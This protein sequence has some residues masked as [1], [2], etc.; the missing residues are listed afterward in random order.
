M[1]KKEKSQ[2]TIA[3]LM[4][5]EG[6]SDNDRSVF[7]NT[8]QKVDISEHVPQNARE[9]STMHDETVNHEKL[10]SVPPFVTREVVKIKNRLAG[11][12]MLVPGSDQHLLRSD[13]YRRI[14]RPL[15]SNAFGKTA[16]L[17]EDGN[18]ILITSSIP[19]EGKT[20][21]AINLALS[22][23]QERD[24]TVLLVDCDV[25][26]RG[27]SLILG[28]ENRSGL[29]E[30]LDSNDLSVGD[31][32]LGT[33]VPSLSLI[34]AGKQHD[35]VTELLA[36]HRMEKIVEE[37]SHRYDDRII[38]FDAPPILSTPLTQVLSGLAG[39][40]VMVIE[41]GKTTQSLVGSALDLLPEGAAVSLVLNK[42]E[43]SSKRDSYYSGY[44]GVTK[45]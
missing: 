9:E 16:Q 28:T 17:V 3:E 32:L 36:S 1:A 44:Y 20:H 42:K 5:R 27:A 31:V 8:P 12:N 39:Q 38:I 18:L 33:D 21:S 13:E 25:I 2:A 23:A 43:G 24:K 22:I 34:A 14:K 45:K 6:V 15:L 10:G 11:L 37:I 35:Y 41:S 4:G 40:I 30:L 29:I 19:R 26:K 7:F